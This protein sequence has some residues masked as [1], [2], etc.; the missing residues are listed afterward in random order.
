M[1]CAIAVLGV[2]FDFDLEQLE[3]RVLDEVQVAV[4]TKRAYRIGAVLASRISVHTPIDARIG[5]S[6]Q[7][8][9]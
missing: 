9:C 6:P 7:R 3:H 1:T 5:S 2:R 4:S 8:L